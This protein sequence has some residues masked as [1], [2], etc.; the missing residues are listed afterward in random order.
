MAFQKTALKN[1]TVAFPGDYYRPPVRAFGAICLDSVKPGLG[2]F[3]PTASTNYEN[4]K[5]SSSSGDV[6][7]GFVVKTNTAL[8]TN[9]LAEATDAFPAGSR[10][11]ICAQG[12]IW[13]TN[14]V[15]G[16]SAATAKLGYKVAVE[17]TTGL[18]S[19]YDPNSTAPA[20]TVETN[21]VVIALASDGSVGSLLVI[22]NDQQLP[23][24]GA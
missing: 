8:M 9:I 19:T 16:G 20:N 24:V 13:V 1:L 12:A 15:T 14:N 4:V 17:K 5:H 7:A 18:V 2:V 21:F 3:V 22:A 11:E 6:F 23:M 10:V